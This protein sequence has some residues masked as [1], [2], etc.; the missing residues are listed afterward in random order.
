MAALVCQ[1]VDRSEQVTAAWSD[2]PA[3][4]GPDHLTGQGLLT[5]NKLAGEARGRLS[6][7]V[8]DHL[9]GSEV[10]S[11]CCLLCGSGRRQSREKCPI[12]PSSHH[13]EDG[14]RR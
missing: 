2:D 8:Q 13:P 4:F 10:A 5:F 6:E 3:S 12:L 14:T 1:V 11:P 7:V 9:P